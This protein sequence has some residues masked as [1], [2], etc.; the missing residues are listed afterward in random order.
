MVSSPERR[1]LAGMLLGLLLVPSHQAFAHGVSLDLHHPWPAESAWH[2][3]FLVPWIDK[4]EAEAGGRMRFHP[5]AGSTLGGQAESLHDQA[6]DGGTDVVWA[7]VRATAD[8]FPALSVFE[9]PFMVRTATGGSRAV[10]E[11]ARINDLPDR[12]FDGTRVLAVHVGD[13]AQLHWVKPPEGADLGGRR[14]AVASAQD[15]AVIAAMGGVPVETDAAGMAEALKSGRADGALLSWSQAAQSG[16]DRVAKA[17]TDFGP[18][19]AGVSST[20]YVFAMSTGSFR[21]LPDDLKAVV[22]ANSGAETAAWLGR[23]MDAAAARAR[24]AAAD[25]GDIVRVVTPEERDKWRQAARPVTDARIRALEQGGVKVKLLL[26]SAREQLNDF[27]K[28]PK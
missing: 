2:R 20:V 1:R 19:Q 9:F 24:K 17:H 7:P 12:D 18:N 8:R 15:G 26:D 14:V 13:P 5:H 27:D 11:Y 25:R 21:G 4:V 22:N 6:R 10:S 16:V 3:E 23:V 28:A